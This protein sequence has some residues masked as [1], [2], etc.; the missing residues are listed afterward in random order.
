M[1]LKKIILILGVLLLVLINK[2]IVNAEEETG[3]GAG[4]SF[5]DPV[6]EFSSDGHVIKGE[7]CIVNSSG[8]GAYNT[9][10]YVVTGEKLYIVKHANNET[11]FNLSIYGEN[12]TYMRTITS[13]NEKHEYV[14]DSKDTR[15]FVNGSMLGTLYGSDSSG[16][17][18]DYCTI[19]IFDDGDPEFNQKVQEYIDRADVS[20]AENA[21]DVT[22][23]PEYS[24]SIE[25]P[26]NLHIVSGT[27]YVL[28][29]R[30]KNVNKDIVINWEQTVDTSDY[31][32]DID[33][34]FYFDDVSNDLDNVPGTVVKQSNSIR[35]AGS[36]NI[37]VKIDKEFMNNI[38]NEDYSH[39]KIV[40]V[41][42]NPPATC[43]LRSM[44]IRV[45]NKVGQDCSNYVSVN[46]NFTD[47]TATASEKD[48]SGNTVENAEYDNTDVLNYDGDDVNG[49]NVGSLKDFNSIITYVKNGFGLFGTGGLVSLLSNFFGNVFPVQFWNLILTG[50]GVVILIGIVNFLLKR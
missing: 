43:Y 32:Y 44:I 35:Y 1:Y 41:T 29:N 11:N 31:M 26:K 13:Y 40:G 24:D 10:V 30:I 45:R 4:Q 47:K 9:I 18:L 46:V 5:G 14:S 38:L 7:L 16:A 28:S 3:G 33:V 48:S 20:G 25:L 8:S 19:P 36:K 42:G 37:T 6:Q 49:G 27:N 50:M 23:S 17:Y 21:L 2:V 12:G 34:E 15:T 39:H 22:P